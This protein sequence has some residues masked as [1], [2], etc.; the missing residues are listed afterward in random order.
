MTLFVRSRLPLAAAAIGAL[1]AG[2]GCVDIVGADIGRFVDRQEKRFATSG[3]PDVDVSTFDGQIEIRAW[4]RPG[5]VLVV[6]EKRARDK[7]DA[8]TIEV[9]TE[10]N[11]NHVTVDARVPKFEHTF[12]ISWHR[13][14]TAKLIVSVPSSSNIVAKSGDG[15]IDI[16][17]VSGRVDLRSGD[18]RIQARDLTGDL[19]AHTGD[20]SIKLDGMNGALDA[21]TGDG[22]ISVS[23]KLTSLHARSGDGSVTIHAASGSAATGDWDITTGDGSVT[24]ELPDGF[25]GELDAHTGDGGI[26]M[27]DISVSN[28]T[29]QISKHTVRGTLGSGGRAVRVRT[30]DGTITLRR[31][32]KADR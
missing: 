16:E 10:Q 14:R 8:D 27:Q 12:G 22:S 11:G 17:R 4:D 1:L 13:S 15:S 7:A 32:L 3:S 6:I 31:S 25:G 28:V 5:E 30:G 20:G 23:G 2:P 19:R 24:L 26:H 18:G 29:G 9:H 21:D